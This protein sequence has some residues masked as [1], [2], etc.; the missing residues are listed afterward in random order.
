MKITMRIQAEQRAPD[1]QAV[2]VFGHPVSLQALQGRMVLLSFYRYA[3][4]PLCNLRV[5]DLREAAPGLAAA[6]VAMVGVF[7]SDAASIRRHAGRLP[8]PFPLVADPD[9]ELYRSYAVERSWVAM[10]R[11]PTLVAA[12]RALA[13]GFRPG[14]IDGPV[15]RTPADF[16][17]G[18]DGRVVLAHYGRHLDD[19]L[20]LDA[21]QAALA[22]PVPRPVLAG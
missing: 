12:V 13:A 9:M 11:W 4:C 6:G 5:R 10:L 1:F 22:T 7:Q 21:I 17:I 18:P 16:L 14:R 15:D 20:P 19:H 8:L 2:D 3:S